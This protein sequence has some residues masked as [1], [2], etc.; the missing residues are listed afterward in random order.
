VSLLIT[1]INKR[2]KISIDA[3]IGI[4][5]SAAT[6][7]G[8]IFISLKTGY[9]GDAYSYLFGTILAISNL[10]VTI[11]SVFFVIA[12]SIIIKYWGKFA[13]ITF[14]R[15]LAISDGINVNLADNLLSILLAISIVISIKIVG[16][17]L[18]SAFLVLPAAIARLFSNTFSK[19]TIIS[20]II[21]CITTLIGL[22]LSF[23]LDLPT[24][25]TII[26]LQSL[27]FGVVALCRKT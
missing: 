15:E 27:I 13:Y 23:I 14:D 8:I 12:M 10:D 3:A 17:V 4:L 9:V 26:I 18:I 11:I 1:Q 19:M 7:L 21:G 22:Y 25:A 24:G 2:T 5:F 20:I 16:I 6:A